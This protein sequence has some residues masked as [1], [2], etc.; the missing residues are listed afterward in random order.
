MDTS[1]P[2]HHC[3][4]SNAL[5][6]CPCQ[7]PLSLLLHHYLVELVFCPILDVSCCCPIPTP[8]ITVLYACLF[9][10]SLPFID[11]LYPCPS[12]LLFING[13][14][15]RL[16]HIHHSSF[17]RVPT[18]GWPSMRNSVPYIS[19]CRTPLASW[20]LEVHPSRSL[21][22]QKKTIRCCSPTSSYLTR[23]CSVHM[24]HTV[25]IGLY[26]LDPHFMVMKHCCCLLSASHLVGAPGCSYSCRVC[27]SPRSRVR[28]CGRAADRAPHECVHRS[29]K[30]PNWPHMP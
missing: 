26:P 25:C 6:C 13:L 8:C 23:G 30:C 14:Y 29:A 9:S 17:I 11:E 28:I 10:V 19:L 24:V 20:T 22:S 5:H 7:C 4:C 2:L 1:L 18:G 15:E 3:L 12:S 21:L 16:S 27:Q